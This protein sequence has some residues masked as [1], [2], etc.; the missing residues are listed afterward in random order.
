MTTF[1]GLLPGIR[2]YICAYFWN[3]MQVIRNAKSGRMYE[4]INI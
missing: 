3:W 1:N 4:N 2:C